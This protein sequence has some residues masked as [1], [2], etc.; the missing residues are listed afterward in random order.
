MSAIEST[1]K[2]ESSPGKGANQSA[3]DSGVE[4]TDEFKVPPVSPIPSKRQATKKVATR[5]SMLNIARRQSKSMMGGIAFEDQVAVIADPGRPVGDRLCSLLRVSL[6]ATLRGMQDALQ[7]E[8]AENAEVDAAMQVSSHLRKAVRTEE[9]DG[10]VL[11]RLAESVGS[12]RKQQVERLNESLLLPSKVRCI[13]NYTKDLN[14]ETTEW[15]RLLSERKKEYTAARAD[16]KAVVSGEKKLTEADLPAEASTE[17][18]L[19]Q[20][21]V[22]RAMARL[23]EQEEELKACASLLDRRRREARRRLADAEAE[24]D[25]AAS[26]IIQRGEEANEEETGL[27]DVFRVRQEMEKEKAVQNGFASKVDTWKREAKETV[28]SADKQ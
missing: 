26:K 24:L 18:L 8:E 12:L 19:A 9:F 7:E 17:P 1:S 11:A 3:R 5:R 25:A 27:L 14:A 22:V 2:K 4:D 15:K 16:K 23:G 21:L 6:S 10:E 28:E 20:N 13:R